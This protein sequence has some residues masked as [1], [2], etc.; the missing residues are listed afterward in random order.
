[1]ASS[2]DVVI[3]GAGPYGLSIAAH[4]LARK[5]PLRIFG[6][7]MQ[8]WLAS[9][10]QG[11]K[12]KSEGFATNLSDPDR[13]F[14]LGAYCAEQ[15]VPY[16]GTGLPVR[17]ETFVAYGQA[18]QRRFVPNL[19]DK[20]VVSLERTPTGFELRL[21]DGERVA[22]RKVVLA[23]GIRSFG[24]IPPELAG[25]PEEYLSHSAD[26]SDL[27]RF[28]GRDVVVIGAGAS[29]MDL[30]ALLRQQGASVSVV[31]RRS[32]VKFQSPLGPRTLYDKIRA[33]MTVLGPGWKSVLCTKAP[34][35]FHMMPEA[36]RVDVV[37]RYLGPGPAWFVRDQVEE[38]I[39]IVTG[40]LVTE[41]RVE[42]DRA[43]LV[44]SHAD[45]RTVGI[46]ADH[47]IAATGYKVDVRR[48]S[49]LSSQLQSELRRA[50]QAPALSMNFESSVPGL[51]FVGT[52]SANSFGP[53]LRFVAGADFT[54]RRLS[55]HLS[56]S[57]SHRSAMDDVPMRSRQ[58]T[59]VSAE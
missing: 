12:L 52:A 38:R 48:L 6:S 19:E 49:F 56:S 55:A 58:P 27:T 41:A 28:A 20:T 53:M 25:L 33:P 18:F 43:H 44:L 34:L 59:K 32:A 13:Q 40:A 57:A 2:T 21:D 3:V 42:N 9:M 31:A 29:A 36:F 35:L 37:R 17:L 22:A 45:G 14:T 15:G 23:A 39:P 50:D 16:S 26:H 5:V 10:P 46:S 11:M 30:A 4:L 8:T 24:Y 47:I 51:Y 54:A 7:P 1:M